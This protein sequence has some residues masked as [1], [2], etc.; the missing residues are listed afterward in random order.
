MSIL[1]KYTQASEKKEDLNKDQD[2][3]EIKA[4]EDAKH[5]LKLQ[6]ATKNLKDVGIEPS[7]PITKGYFFFIEAT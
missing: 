7:T 4:L 5:N 6:I 3:H 1:L 2:L